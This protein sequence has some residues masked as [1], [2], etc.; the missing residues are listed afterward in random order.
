[1]PAN[2]KRETPKEF[3]FDSDSD[4]HF[5]QLYKGMHDSLAW[6]W[7]DG[8]AKLIYISMRYK[9]GPGTQFKLRF[10]MSYSE[11]T[12][13]AGARRG[14][15]RKYIEELIVAGFIA[16]EVWGA[17]SVNEYSFSDKWK[18][19]QNKQNV[20]RLDAA[21]DRFKTKQAGA[22]ANREAAT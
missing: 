19:V 12:I 20:K 11:M 14:S 13:E 8:P 16:V 18:N 7:L 21:M 5:I 10:R 3:C 17:R 15:I 2:K 9:Y 6:R 4:T 1:M 22:K